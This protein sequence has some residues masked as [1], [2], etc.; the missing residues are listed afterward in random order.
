MC[1]PNTLKR[2]A[3]IGVSS[4]GNSCVESNEHIELTSKV[5]KDSKRESM[6]TAVGGE[7]RVLRDGAKRKKSTHGHG[8]Q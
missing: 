7:V 5:E 8:E 1:S 3:F 4:S 6:M 2:R